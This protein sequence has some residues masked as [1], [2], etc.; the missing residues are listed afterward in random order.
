MIHIVLPYPP[1]SNNLYAT[2]GHRR[3]LSSAGRAYKKTVAECC[4]I[5][6]VGVPLPL[7]T[8]LALILWISPPT[9]RHYDMDGKVKVVQDALQDAGVFVNDEQIDELHVYRCGIHPGGMA[10]VILLE[11]AIEYSVYP[12]GEGC[13]GLYHQGAL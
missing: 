5:E 12:H 10:E 1:S 2:V 3:V 9:R 8:R 6:L 11:Y 13:E 7:T 4:L